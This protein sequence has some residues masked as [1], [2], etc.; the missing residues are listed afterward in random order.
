MSLDINI[1]LDYTFQTKQFIQRTLLGFKSKVIDILFRTKTKY[2][3]TVWLSD[4][5]G[6]SYCNNTFCYSARTPV[7]KLIINNQFECHT[8][9][10]REAVYRQQIQ[11]KFE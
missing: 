3:D 4:V 1:V 8:V 5:N 2:C 10:S 11:E 9:L 6:A 7:S